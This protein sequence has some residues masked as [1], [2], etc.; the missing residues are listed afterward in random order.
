MDGVG[1][2]ALLAYLRGYD[3]LGFN[4]RRPPETRG[5]LDQKLETLRS[6]ERWWYERLSEGVA[7]WYGSLGGEAEDGGWELG[8][9]KPQTAALR[10]DFERWRKDRPFHGDLPGEREFGKLLRKLS[11]SVSGPGFPRGGPSRAYV[12]AGVR[13]MS[14][15]FQRLVERRRA[16][17]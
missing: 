4:V 14:L 6:V 8:A 12:P 2:A 11:R 13:G 15:A 16:E 9:I 3:L 7:P 5:L 1:P 17:N 10:G